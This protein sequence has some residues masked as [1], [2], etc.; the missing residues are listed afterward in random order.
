MKKWFFLLLILVL[1]SSTCFTINAADIPRRDATKV[2]DV[3]EP[4]EATEYIVSPK[5]EPD[6][7]QT[8]SNAKECDI[9]AVIACYD[10]EY[11]RVDILLENRIT[12]DWDIFYAV[13][14]EYTGMNEYFTY[15]TDTKK[16]IYERE[17]DGE[18]VKTQRLTE[19]NSYDTAGVTS[20]DIK[21]SDVYFIINKKEHIN[22]E[23]GKRYF[24]TCSFMSGFITDK[25]NLNIADKTIPVDLYFVF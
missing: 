14:F 10:D 20:S 19:D 21:D 16:L 8:V 15:F 18:L 6:D 11:I 24:L 9:R 12:Y 3:T 4:Y 1:V 25:G 2:D 7:D 17:V 23:K 13:K 22:G 5:E